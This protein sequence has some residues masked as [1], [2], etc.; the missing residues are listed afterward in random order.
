MK[1]LLILGLLVL[2]A[3][4]PSAADKRAEAFNIALD[5]CTDRLVHKYDIDYA[6]AERKCEQ[7]PHRETL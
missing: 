7:N 3:C 6:F 5:E 2:S 4:G 1:R